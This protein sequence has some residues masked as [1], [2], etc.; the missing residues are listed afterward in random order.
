MEERE[1][2]LADLSVH[3]CV[4]ESLYVYVCL[5]LSLCVYPDN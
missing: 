5:C 2:G 4:S 1:G 3:A